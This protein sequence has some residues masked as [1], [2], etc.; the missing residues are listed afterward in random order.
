M[1]TYIR[2]ITSIFFF[3]IS[4]GTYALG[5]DSIR[6]KLA[7]DS[8]GLSEMSWFIGGSRRNYVDPDSTLGHINII[9]RDSKGQIDSAST[10]NAKIIK[11]VNGSRNAE[12]LYQ[13]KEE[14]Q[15]LMRFLI[16]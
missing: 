15:I 9:Y 16:G 6:I 10:S 12:I 11:T 8:S 3:V 2:N 1:N 13:I 7:N 14:F 5:D 4:S